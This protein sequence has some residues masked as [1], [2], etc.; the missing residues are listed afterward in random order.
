MRLLS[1]IFSGTIH[2][3]IVPDFFGAILAVTAIASRLALSLL[4]QWSK[5]SFLI[6]FS[7]I[8]NLI[9]L[10]NKIELVVFYYIWPF[11]SQKRT[12]LI[13]GIFYP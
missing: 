5:I 1:S 6:V 10:K 11:P 7:N 4:R 12:T 9:D 8:L 2:R 3:W 13:C